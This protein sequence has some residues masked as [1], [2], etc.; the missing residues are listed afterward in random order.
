MC[1]YYNY[2][3]LYTYIY[4]FYLQ[5]FHYAFPGIPNS[6]CFVVIAKYIKVNKSL[7][8]K[9]LRW[10]RRE[11]THSQEC[12]QQQYLNCQNL[13]EPKC[14]TL[15]Q[16]KKLY[17]TTQWNTWS[18]N[19]IL[20]CSKNKL[21]TTTRGI[22]QMG[23]WMWDVRYK[24]MWSFNGHEYRTSMHAKFKN[25]QNQSKAWAAKRVIN[26]WGRE[27]NREQEEGDARRLQGM[28]DVS[29]FTWE[30]VAQEYLFCNN[31]LN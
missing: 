11:F 29:L 28:S 6:K 27:G 15:K 9:E 31:S 19:R 25:K 24:R 17:I 14:T 23:C 26:S 16:I 21:H 18:Y 3:H 8:F 20:Y 30:I 13:K 10:G 4:K 22:S 7:T 12:S 1:I 2:V 5:N